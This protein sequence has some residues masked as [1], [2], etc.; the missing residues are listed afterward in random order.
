MN[1]YTST[2]EPRRFTLDLGRPMRPTGPPPMVVVRFTDQLPDW[3]RRPVFRAPRPKLSAHQ[4][5]RRR[6]RARLARRGW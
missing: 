1:F 4:R 2:P 6:I 5:R 3:M